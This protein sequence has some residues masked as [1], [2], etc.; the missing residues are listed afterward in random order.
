LLEAGGTSRDEFLARYPLLANKLADYIDV[1]ELVHGAA[2]EVR[3]AADSLAMSS[4]QPPTLSDY[5]ILREIGRGGMGIVYD[6][7]HVPLA[8]RVALKV[9]PLVSSFDSTRLRRFKSEAQAVARLRHPNIVSVHSVGSEGDVHYYAMELIDG[10]S[11]ST[12]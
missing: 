10:Y 11:L 4:I 3:N 5:T 6:T 12:A 1:L 7:L 8:R 2:E 9:L